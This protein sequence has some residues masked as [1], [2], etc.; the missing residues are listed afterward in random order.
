[1]LNSFD[2]DDPVG[3]QSNAP[4]A[5]TKDAIAPKISV[6]AGKRKRGDSIDALERPEARPW[7]EENERSE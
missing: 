6:T 7:K 5:I 2:K 1:L 4:A 3:I